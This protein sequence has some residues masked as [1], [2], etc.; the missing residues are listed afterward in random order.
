MRSTAKRMNET[1]SENFNDVSE[2]T[3]CIIASTIPLYC[4]LRRLFR[5]LVDAQIVNE[6][7][8]GRN[9]YSLH[10]AN[11]CLGIMFGWTEISAVIV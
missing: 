10:A 1:R 5:S 11:R 2:Y 7:Q 8:D 3:Y 4:L 9:G 6:F